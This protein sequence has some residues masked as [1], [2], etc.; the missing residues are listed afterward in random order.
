MRDLSLWR[1]TPVASVF[2]LIITAAA[3]AAAQ[4]PAAPSTAPAAPSAAPAAPAA[5]AAPAPAAAPP[6][7]GYAY[8]PPPP[9]YAYAYPAPPVY[10]AYPTPLRAPESV[11]YH[12][13]PVPDGYHVEERA[14]RGLIIGGSLVLGIPWVLGITIASGYD[15]SNQSGWLVV[16]ALGPWITI[17][18]RRKD[19]TCDFSGSS[20]INCTEDN[21][22]RTML[23]LDGLTQAA[24]AIMLVYGLASP[25]KVITRN[26]VGSLHF[27]PARMGRLGYGGVLTGEF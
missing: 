6:P 13:G 21:S 19:T 1:V 12:G 24:G 20:G 11:P 3:P 5:A 7:A 14:Q 26:F 16:P 18:A 17:A 9:G 15:F 22:V 27:T 2:C 8:P 10:G 25:K 23:I 4:T